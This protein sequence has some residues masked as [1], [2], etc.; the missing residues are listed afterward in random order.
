MEVVEDQLCGGGVL[1]LGNGED[2]FADCK[3]LGIENVFCGVDLVVPPFEEQVGLALGEGES[4]E[5]GVLVWDGV[6]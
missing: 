5:W 2:L 6:L 1:F 3:V 4:I